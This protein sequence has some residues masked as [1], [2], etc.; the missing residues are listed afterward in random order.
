M[1]RTFGKLGIF[2]LFIEPDV[3]ALLCFH[4]QHVALQCALVNRRSFSGCGWRAVL[5]QVTPVR[6]SGG[7]ILMAR[8][9]RRLRLHSIDEQSSHLL[10]H[11]GVLSSG[12]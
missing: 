7:V 8:L 11:L 1:L 5:A 9:L 4:G 3:S 6:V 12:M 10:S 2:L